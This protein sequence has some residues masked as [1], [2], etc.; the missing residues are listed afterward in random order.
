MRSDGRDDG[1]RLAGWRGHVATM[2]A[3]ETRPPKG[4]RPD[5]WRAFL[6]DALAFVETWGAEA[7]ALGWS[8]LAAFGVHPEAP[9]ANYAAMGL[10]P[11][12]RGA[13]VTSLAEDRAET[14][15]GA[16]GSVL[17]FRRRPLPLATVPI[18]FLTSHANLAAAA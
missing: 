9:A 18:W 15:R 13:S 14:R 4:Y 11:M 8:D 17:V 3:R 6:R 2:A 5:D 16:R 10:V 1:E 7:E 12:L